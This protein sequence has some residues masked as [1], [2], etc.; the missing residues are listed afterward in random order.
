MTVGA[1]LRAALPSTNFH[2]ECKFQEFHAYGTTA[3]PRRRTRADTNK[4]PPSCYNTSRHLP[5]VVERE[6]DIRAQAPRQ[7]GRH[8]GVAL[9]EVGQ[10]DPLSPHPLPDREGLGHGAVLLVPGLL[11]GQK[12][13]VID[14][15]EKGEKRRRRERPKKKKNKKGVRR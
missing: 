9:A 4:L 11:V 2:P 12:D 15:P 7:R 6:A 14:A 10:D 13:E 1:N 8:V 5:H 3:H